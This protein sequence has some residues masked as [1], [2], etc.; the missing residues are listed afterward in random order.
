MS[1]VIY[2]RER[3]WITH[4]AS[5]VV[6]LRGCAQYREA[7]ILISTVIFSNW[8]DTLMV[9][10]YIFLS[11]AAGEGPVAFINLK[12]MKLHCS[13][14]QNKEAKYTISKLSQH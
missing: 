2:Q 10:V 12:S 6:A 11:D 7:G 13:H 1:A 9:N 3:L 5:T 8:A 4:V 14:R